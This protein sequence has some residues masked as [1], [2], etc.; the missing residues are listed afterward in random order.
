MGRKK[1]SIFN[2]SLFLFPKKRNCGARNVV[3]PQILTACRPSL[4]GLTNISNDFHPNAKDTAGWPKHSM[5][6]MQA[7]R[8]A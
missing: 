2:G 4:I 5:P 6:T 3:L 7:G 1:K 8:Q